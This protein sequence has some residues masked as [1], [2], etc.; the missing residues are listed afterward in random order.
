MRLAEGGLEVSRIVFG[1]MGRRAS[2]EAE[3]TR[4]LHA[5]IEA[6]T[7]SIDTAP[8]YDF[9]EVESFLGRA[10]RDRRSSVEILSKVGLRWDAE[11]GEILFE[12]H[13]ATGTRR[14]VRRDSR[15]AAI[16][17]DVEA[18]LERLRTDHLDL[19]QI[20][21]PDRHTPIEDSLGELD[22]LAHEGKIRHVGV[23]NFDA[24]LLEAALLPTLSA[25]GPTRAH[26]LAH[27][28]V[29][30]QIHF[31]LLTQDQAKALADVTR[32][33]DVGWLA[34]SP[35]EAGA[36][37]DAMLTP[38]R[39]DAATRARSH[40]FRPANAERIRKALADVVSPIAATHGASISQICLAWLLHQDFVRGVIAGA[41][42]AEQARANAE[43]VRIVLDPD[44]LSALADRFAGLRLDPLAGQG[45]RNRGAHLLGRVRRKAR[46]LLGSA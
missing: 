37:S 29:S 25:H 11:H 18:S 20:H 5:A 2:S 32:R 34:Y 17:R 22:R 1:S 13:D 26:S 15:P 9:G 4:T 36:L 43:A 33:F 46:R 16:R 31:S 35:L 28:V 39:L 27:P 41:S 44:E 8:L 10:L 21:Y 7:S 42:D 12:F 38:G 14:A 3:R 45:W 24:G 19:C 23:S 30:N 6:G 40:H